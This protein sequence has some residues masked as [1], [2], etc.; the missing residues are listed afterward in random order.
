MN[1]TFERGSAQDPSAQSSLWWDE[2]CFYVK[3]R[4]ASCMECYSIGNDFVTMIARVVPSRTKGLL[5]VVGRVKH[6]AVILHRR[7]VLDAILGDLLHYLWRVGL[8]ATSPMRWEAYLL[9]MSHDPVSPVWG[10]SMHSQIVGKLGYCNVNYILKIPACPRTHLEVHSLQEKGTNLSFCVTSQLIC[11]PVS[12]AK[13]LSLGT[14]NSNWHWIWQHWWCK[15]MHDSLVLHPQVFR[16]T[17]QLLFW[18]KQPQ[19]LD[20]TQKANPETEILP[21]AQKAL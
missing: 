4:R 18:Q 13:F 21:W 1:V 11:F 3:N 17:S 8:V 10:C 6:A 20:A 5:G 16:W 14:P 9:W 12:I 19:N 7:L 2:W 15:K